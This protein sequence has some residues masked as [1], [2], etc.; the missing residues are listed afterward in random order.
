MDKF[1]EIPRTDVSAEREN[2]WFERCESNQIPFITVKTRTKYADVHWDYIAYSKEVDEVLGGL[3]TR[4]RDNAIDIFKKY[5][6]ANSRYAAS[7][8][9]VWFKNLEIESA[10]L[11][12][13][14]LY[15]LIAES[16]NRSNA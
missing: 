9:L 15:D 6:N 1:V 12:A 16:V 8:H 2:A 11:A 10:R 7:G 4:L 5:A 3:G 13:S 14:E